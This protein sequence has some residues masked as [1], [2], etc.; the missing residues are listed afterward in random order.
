M[1]WGKHA[2]K[3]KSRPGV[4]TCSAFV[5]ISCALSLACWS[6]AAFGP[7][8]TYFVYVM[9]AFFNN[10]HRPHR[11]R[12]EWTASSAKFVPAHPS[13]EIVNAMK[14]QAKRPCN[15]SCHQCSN[16]SWE[17][18]WQR[19]LA[20]IWRTPKPAQLNVWGLQQLRCQWFEFVLFTFFQH[21]S[22]TISVF[23]GQ[24]TRRNYLLRTRNP[25][26]STSTSATTFWATY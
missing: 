12:S 24:T 11:P 22:R 15:H 6:P 10:W 23:A 9:I 26:S 25:S 7:P 20:S 13:D 21:N 8:N 5:S 3:C 19:S 17:K 16:M 2:A 18:P 1:L 4:Q 14:F